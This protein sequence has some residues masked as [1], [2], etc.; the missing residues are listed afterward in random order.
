MNNT[1]NITTDKIIPRLPERIRIQCLPTPFIA[2]ILGS[3]LFTI[4]LAINGFLAPGGG[5]IFSGD[6]FDQFLPFSFSLLRS[7]KGE[8]DFWYSFSLYAGSGTILAYLVYAFNPFNILYLIPGLSIITVSHIISVIKAGLSAAAFSIYSTRVLKQDRKSALVFSLCYAFSSWAVT[9]SIIYGWIDCL[10]VFPIIIT[11]LSSIIKKANRKL[12]VQLTLCYAYLFITHF[13][14]GYVAGIFTLIYYVYEVMCDTI[15]NHAHSGIS[16][17]ILHV[18]KKLLILAS[19][20]ILAAALDAAFLLPGAYFLF[21][22][23]GDSWVPF[24]ELRST[25]PD[26]INAMFACNTSGLASTVPYIYCGIPVLLLVPFYFINKAIDLPH[27]IGAAAIL[28][29]YACSSLFL[30]LYK[31][32][33]A[34]DNP[35][36]LPFRFSPCICFFLVSLAAMVWQKRKD[37][38]PKIIYFITIVLLVFLY[39]TCKPITVSYFI[40]N[41]VF[42]LLWLILIIKLPVNR[43]E[44]TQTQPNA[45]HL[46]FI[47]VFIILASELLISSSVSMRAF[48]GASSDSLDRENAHDLYAWYNAEKKSINKIKEEDPTF[49]RIRVNNEKDFNG[50]SFFGANTLTTVVSFE[51]LAMKKAFSHLGIGNAHLMQYDITGLPITDMIFDIKYVIDIPTDETTGKPKITPNKNTLSLAYMVSPDIASYSANE[52]PFENINQLISCMTGKEIKIFDA[53]SPDMIY[54]QTFNM[55]INYT[56]ESTTYEIASKDDKKACI[57]YA[58]PIKEGSIPYMYFNPLGESGFDLQYPFFTRKTPIGINCVLTIPNG[59]L[60]E[61]DRDAQSVPLVSDNFDSDSYTYRSVYMD[62][63]SY[64]SY[65]SCSFSDLSFAYYNT[66]AINE[67]YDCLKDGVMEINSYR[68]SHIEGSVT[69]TEDKPILFTSIP[70]DKGWSAYVD[71]SPAQIYLTTDD[72]FCALVLSPGEHNIVFDY[73]PP[74]ALA[75]SI[76][77]TIAILILLIIYIVRSSTKQTSESNSQKKITVS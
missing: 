40:I 54:M 69:A 67:A 5:S 12:F 63:D 22:H 74:F 59:A 62:M 43:A 31:F 48:A 41:A 4:L 57:T 35:D 14:M 53:I 68:D 1:D 20:A 73:T 7:L 6:N 52:D 38:Q 44:T 65:A 17:N 70:Y 26:I 56:N 72:A 2:F 27:K 11:I 28:I 51:N 21:S 32:L 64:N 23:L 66:D 75:G 42:M 24:S 9:M 60:N 25:I 47:A 8:Q 3:F 45:N 34:F 33:H 61:V 36:Q 30:P 71:G 55:N 77:S 46:W 16:L 18:I 15:S 10:Y 19:S 50:A 76:I 29:F 13:Y 49:Y 58:V 39:I 37:I